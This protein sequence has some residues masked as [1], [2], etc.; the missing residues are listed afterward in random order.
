[1]AG[2][3]WLWWFADATAWILS[4][5]LGGAYS[6]TDP[7]W[8]SFE[9][10]DPPLVEFAPYG[11]ADGYPTFNPDLILNELIREQ[12]RLDLEAAATR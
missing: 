8:L 11:T 2:G 10:S 9:E 6:G 5:E 1:M 4:S 3:W 12:R 7:Y